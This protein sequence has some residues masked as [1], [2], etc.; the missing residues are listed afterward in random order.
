MDV[1]ELVPVVALGERG[2]VARLEERAA[3]D[4]FHEEEVAGLGLVP[5]ADDAVD[6]L[7]GRARA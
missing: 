7:R 6:D 5:A 1:A 4:G 3:G 2:V